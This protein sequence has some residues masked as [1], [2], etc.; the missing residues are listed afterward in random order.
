MIQTNSKGRNCSYGQLELLCFARCF[1]NEGDGRLRSREAPFLKR[2]GPILITYHSLG[3]T[4]GTNEILSKL[5]NNRLF[6]T[7]E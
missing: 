7:A 3:L 4:N 5:S 1:Q 6:P 2:D